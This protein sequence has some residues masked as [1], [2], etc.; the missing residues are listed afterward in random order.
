MERLQ[1]VIAQAGVCSRRK[2][3]Q[4]IVAGR[5]KVD[6]VKVVELGTKVKGNQK[7]EVD[8]VEINKESKVYYVLNKPRNV[9]CSVSDDRE[10]ET[11]IDIIDEEK[12]IYPVGRLDFDTTGLLLLTNDGEFSN[13]LTHPRY[14]IPKYYDVTVKGLV[15]NEDIKKMEQGIELED[16]IT[17]P[18]KV[19][20]TVVNPDK[21]I[22]VLSLRI[23]EG[24]NRQIKRMM[25]A[26]GFEVKRLHR[27]RL[28]NLD[29]TGLNQGDYRRLKPF[30]IKALKAMANERKV[31]VK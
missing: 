17:Q 1:K 16:G 12:R 25:E 8:G 4:L 29:L 10:R 11:V 24:R 3:E 14:H 20:L 19:R 21:G 22:S 18:A 9:L 5:V 26:L 27:K 6:G 7:I 2:A 28:G 30:E 13:E 15:S 31:L 23:T